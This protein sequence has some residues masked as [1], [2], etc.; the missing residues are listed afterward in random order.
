MFDSWPVAICVQVVQCT[1]ILCA[2]APHFKTF[3]ES[4]QS[5][6]LRLY[7]LPG[8]TSR[9]GS[10][11]DGLRPSNTGGSSRARNI[12]H[13]SRRYL[14]LDRIRTRSGEFQTT[15]TASRKAP[16]WDRESQSSRTG[17]IQETKTWTV[18]QERADSG[19]SGQI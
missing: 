11:S 5:S 1:S 10:R 2:S 18:T 3:M 7:D 4:L 9:Y 8:K 6:G 14:E 15:V 13:R 12:S 16:N 17:I 19:A